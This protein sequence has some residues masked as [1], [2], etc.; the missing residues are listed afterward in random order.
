MGIMITTALLPSG[1][2]VFPIAHCVVLDTLAKFKKKFP[3]HFNDFAGNLLSTSSLWVNAAQKRRFH[4]HTLSLLKKFGM[5]TMDGRILP[6]VRETL[7]LHFVNDGNGHFSSPEDVLTEN[8]KIA[9]AA[10]FVRSSLNAQQ[11]HTFQNT[12]AL[13]IIQE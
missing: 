10:E 11:A 2:K 9:A 4:P 7:K 6:I 8:E 3:L 1:Y 13:T 12:L 5:M